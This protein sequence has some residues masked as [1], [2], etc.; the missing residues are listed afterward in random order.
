M[1]KKYIEQIKMLLEKNIDYYCLERGGGVEPCFHINTNDHIWIMT[2]CREILKEKATIKN[3]KEKIYINKIQKL[4]WKNR[5][6]Y[7]TCDYGLPDAPYLL[8]RMTKYYYKIMK[9][10]DKLLGGK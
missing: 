10:I 6:I 8:N 1:N 7:D 2:Y 4:I 3:I 5:R 9:I